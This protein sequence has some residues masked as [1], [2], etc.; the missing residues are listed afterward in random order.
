MSKNKCESAE[1]E[2]RDVILPEEPMEEQLVIAEVVEVPTD[3]IEV[4]EVAEAPEVE[5]P[6]PEVD[7]ITPEVTID[8]SQGEEIVDHELVQDVVAAVDDEQPTES[9]I[10]EPAPRD[11]MAEAKRLMEAHP[12][13]THTSVPDEVFK[14]CAETNT[15]MLEAYDAY[16][17]KKL[18]CDME[19][20]RAE[21]AALKHNAEAMLH[22]PV[23]GVNIAS[24]PIS[25]AE[26]SFLR[27]FNRI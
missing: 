17:I 6:A 26:D 8:N 19:K 21:N 10:P 22:A 16:L 20:L 13:L 7:V 4:A 5:A 14:V 23:T 9:P 1:R 25:E 15:P 18:K 3:T 12:E 11:Y 2:E 27:G 24:A